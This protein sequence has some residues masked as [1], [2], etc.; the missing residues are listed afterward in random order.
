MD[1]QKILIV[2][3]DTRNIFAL[4]A[5]LKSKGYSCI[6][7]HGASEALELLN[8]HQNIGIILLDMMM[9]EMDGYETISTIRSGEK[10]HL[11]IISI[12]AQAMV[13]DREKCLDAGAD[14]YL[15]KP[16]DVDK[17]LDILKRYL[18]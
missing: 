15:P 11:P 6:S 12:T 18:K 7:A 4:K 5:V 14:G 17:L 16:I 1:T 3:D 8:D 2:D 13:G 10:K 9:P